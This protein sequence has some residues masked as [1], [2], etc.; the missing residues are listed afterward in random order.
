MTLKEFKSV[1]NTQISLQGK[2]KRTMQNRKKDFDTLYQAQ[3]ENEQKKDLIQNDVKKFEMNEFELEDFPLET[4]NIFL[5]RELDNNPVLWI[6]V[7]PDME[8]IRKVSI[9]QD[10]RNNWLFQLLR[11]NDIIGQIEAA[12]RLHVYNEDLVYGILKTVAGSENYFYKVRR[13]VLKSLNKME[14]F[15]FSQY[16]SHEMFLLKLFNQNRLITGTTIANST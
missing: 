7:D 10:K 16:I 12:R 6:R 15:A 4:K 14:I 2:V 13:E 8:F 11:E 1:V 9:V 5:G 3:G